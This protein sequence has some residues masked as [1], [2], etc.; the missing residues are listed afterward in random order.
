MSMSNRTVLVVDDEASQRDLMRRILHL[1]AYTVLETSDYD[2]ALAVQQVHLG[3][4]DLILIDLRLPGGHGYDL[5]KSLLAIEPH[6]KVLYI[7]GQAG[8][9]LCKFFDMEVTDVH[10]LQ[11]PF[12]PAE[13]LQRVKFLLEM[14]DPLADSASAS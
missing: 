7:S 5:S 2:D 9:E 10:F 14:P 8:S 6:L 3:E 1:E 12:K 4:I 11:K 13:L